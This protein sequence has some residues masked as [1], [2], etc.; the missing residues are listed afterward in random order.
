MKTYQF[1]YSGTSERFNPLENM[2]IL[3]IYVWRLY[4]SED[5]EKSKQTKSGPGST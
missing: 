2:H 5:E 3:N 1:K 4:Y